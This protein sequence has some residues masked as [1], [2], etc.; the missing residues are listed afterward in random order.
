MFKRLID[1]NLSFTDFDFF[2]GAMESALALCEVSDELQS[3][4]RAVQ[5][6]FNIRRQERDRFNDFYNSLASLWNFCKTVVLADGKC[7]YC[8]ITHILK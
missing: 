8:M 6:A 3:R 5:E 2:D 7:P 4:T 1:G